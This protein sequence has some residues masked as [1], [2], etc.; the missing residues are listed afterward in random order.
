LVLAWTIAQPGITCA[1]V[2]AKRP[3]QIQENAGAMSWTLTPAEVAAIDAAL[4]RRGP[5]VSRSAV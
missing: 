3:D 5:A 2:G 1:L 4:K